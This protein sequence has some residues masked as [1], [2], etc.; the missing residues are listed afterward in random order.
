MLGINKVGETGESFPSTHFERSI[1][2][3]PKWL[4]K[5]VRAFSKSGTTLKN[6]D[7]LFS[8]LIPADVSFYLEQV[9]V[10]SKHPALRPYFESFNMFSYADKAS[11]GANMSNQKAAKKYNELMSILGRGYEANNKSNFEPSDS[12]VENNTSSSGYGDTRKYVDPVEEQLGSRESI[13]AI[14]GVNANDPDVDLHNLLVIIEELD[15]DTLIIR[16]EMI[17]PDQTKITQIVN[18]TE[19]NIRKIT[20]YYEI[21]Q[22]M[23]SPV[24]KYYTRLVLLSPNS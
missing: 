22:V 21:K 4:D 13:A 23:A 24:G 17:D 6:I 5:R 19:T 12:Y 16:L 10:I 2:F 15:A 14:L 3:I 11:W 9:S 1:I 20:Q 18:Q 8:I 7:G